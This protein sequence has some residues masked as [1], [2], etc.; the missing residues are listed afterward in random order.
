M[1][2]IVHSFDFSYV[3]GFTI[4]EN[5]NVVKTESGGLYTLGFRVVFEL[6]IGFNVIN[7]PH[8]QLSYVQNGV[9]RTVD[10]NDSVSNN[11]YICE[12]NSSQYLS[13][14]TD[15][16]SVVIA[17]ASI[18]SPFQND[19]PTVRVQQVSNSNINAI[20]NNRFDAQQNNADLGKFIY[21]LLRYP[22]E[23]STDV[24]ADI[25]LGYLVLNEQAYLIDEQFYNFELFNGVVNGYYGD[26]RDISNSE[27]FLFLPF[28]DSKYQLDSKYINTTIKIKY[29]CDILANKCIIQ[30]FSND[31]LIDCLDVILGYN[32]PY[33]FL[34]NDVYVEKTVSDT[35]KNF[36]NPKIIIEQNLAT[37]NIYDIDFSGTISDFSNGDFVAIDDFSEIKPTENNEDFERLFDILEKGFYI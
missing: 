12:W 13:P 32:I 30:I 5:S 14:S 19:Y 2:E 11:L 3:S 24:L 20:A 26:N 27:I 23:V 16:E 10:S 8:I 25:I 29:R 22:F 28:Y 34:T 1:S 6:P 37:D 7:T 18:F 15:F 31:T 17:N 36:D 21:S 33:I 35:L 9:S 4:Y